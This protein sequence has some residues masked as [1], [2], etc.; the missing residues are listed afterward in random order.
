MQKVVI[1][2]GA[3]MISV[4]LLS[5]SASAQ[6]T[7]DKIEGTGKELKGSVKE[8]IGKAVGD[9]KLESDGKADKVEGKIQN[10]IGGVKDALRK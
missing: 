1:L 3:A 6:G 9:A 7:T 8:T 4:A 2:A 5:G 10:A